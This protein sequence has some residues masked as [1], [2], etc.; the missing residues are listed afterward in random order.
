M[1]EYQEC[2]LCPRECKVNRL[3]GQLGFCKNSSRLKV[4]RASLHFF[5]EPCLSGTNGSGAVF[6]SGCSLKCIYC[7]NHEIS[8]ENF[9]KEI[10][11]KH[12]ADI[13]LSLQKQGANNINLVTPTH[14]VPSIIEALKLAKQ[15]GLTLPIVYNSSGYESLETLK[16]L[17]GLIDI[18]LPDFKY[19][20]NELAYQY[21]K[22]G[23]YVEKAK[24]AIDMMYK[25]VGSPIF[26]DDGIMIKG[27][28]VRHLLLPTRLNDA[29]KIIAYL[30]QKYGDDIY[31]SIMNQYTPLIEVRNI[32]PL[33][34][35]VDQKDYDELIDYALDLGVKNAYMQEGK[36]Q[37]ESFIP[38][39]DTTG[40]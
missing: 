16:L 19:Y 34:Q 36:T 11:T 25:Q 26:N 30:Y 37:S 10:T 17:D 38:K 3:E 21:S 13:F 24:L 14:F 15:N 1:I 29:K 23:D 5:E 8:E 27:L 33:N 28:M 12:L 4:A 35:V 31:L 6:F 18:Y 39:F 20:S 2:K 40:V 7:Q 9:G 32:P 22:A